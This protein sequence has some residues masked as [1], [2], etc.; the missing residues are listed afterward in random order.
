MKIHKTE[1]EILEFKYRPDDILSVKVDENG[2][3]VKEQNE[4]QEMFVERLKKQ[5]TEFNRVIAATEWVSKEM[6]NLIYFINIPDHTNEELQK[7][8]INYYYKNKIQ[9]V[10]ATFNLI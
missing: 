7:I 5:S 10:F 6:N 8:I 1:G 3:I 9:Y 2:F 4:T